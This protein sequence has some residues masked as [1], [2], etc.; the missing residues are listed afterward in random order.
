MLVMA[1]EL[2]FFFV[3][4]KKMFFNYL[5][6][7][8]FKGNFNFLL[9]QYFDH[10]LLFKQTKEEFNFQINFMISYSY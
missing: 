1:Y 4:L 7:F 3:L 8:L 5:F 9:F 6:H 10:Q 2:Y